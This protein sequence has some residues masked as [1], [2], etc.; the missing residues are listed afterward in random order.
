MLKSLRLVL[1]V[2]LFLG[3]VLG[4]GTSSLSQEKYVLKI[5][6]SCPTDDVYQIIV[7]KFAEE[8]KN[9]VG[10]IVEVKIFPNGQL[11]TEQEFIDGLL[12]GTIEGTICGRGSQIDQRLDVYNLPF[13]FNNEE[14]IDKVISYGTEI[15]KILDDIFL[16]HGYVCLMNY[17]PGFRQVTTHNKSIKS[18][19]DLKNL[20]IRVSNPVV[21]AA[22]KAWGANPTTINYGELYTALQLG[23]VE[24]QENP[25][26]N[27]YTMKFYEVQDHINLTSHGVTPIQFL[28]SKKFW[29]TLPKDIQDNM[30]I[31]S[32]KTIDFAQP[33]IRKSN[34]DLVSEL[35][36]LGMTVTWEDEI[37][38][39]SF[40][41]AMRELYKDYYDSIGEELIK[42][43]ID[44]GK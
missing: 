42:K 20:D 43:V 25:A 30:I 3:F 21:Q 7:T 27:I 34:Q 22:F 15:R 24:A 17:D 11:G 8:L 13:I 19:E 40:V 29:D 35:E 36:K 16:E 26:V 41:P 33:L 1:C 4:F 2:T 10:D 37:D 23:V 32:N 6:H 38:R 28:L 31:A 9:L 14:H 12:M 44:A 18:V 5:A 39:D